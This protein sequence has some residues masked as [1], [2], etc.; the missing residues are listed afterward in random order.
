MFATF[1]VFSTDV[2]R[3][4]TLVD[5]INISLRQLRWLLNARGI[6][7]YGAI[8]KKDLSDLVSASGPVTQVCPD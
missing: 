5:P 3:V 8:E 4:A 2:A 1:I 7:Y 6:N